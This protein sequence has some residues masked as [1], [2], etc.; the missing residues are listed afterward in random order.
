MQNPIIK[1][2]KMFH[3]NPPPPPTPWKQL[4]ECFQIFPEFYAIPNLLFWT[5]KHILDIAHNDVLFES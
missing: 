3:D 1:I 5:N 2:Y 4:T